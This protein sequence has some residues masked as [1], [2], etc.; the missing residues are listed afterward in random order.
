MIWIRADANSNIGTG[1][2]MRCMSIGHALREC[3]QEVCFLL[4]DASGAK[5]LESRGFSYRILHTNYQDMESELPKLCKWL[6]ENAVS[7]LLIDSYYVTR[8]YLMELRSFTRTAYVD[9]M[10]AFPYPVDLLVNYNIYGDM[11]PYREQAAL[12]DTR[13][14]LGTDYVPLREEFKQVEY[15]VR[16]QGEHVLVTTGGSDLY[17]LAGQLLEKALQKEETRNLHYH[18]VSGA[19]NKNLPALL[20]LEAKYPNVHIY[21]NVTNMA[22]LMRQCDVA[23]SAGGS[24]MYELCAVGVPIIC[25]SFVDNQEQ[26]VQTF[27]KKEVVCYGGNYL[28]QKESLLDDIVKQLA[29]LAGHKEIREQYS[30]RQRRLVDGHGAMRIARELCAQ[31]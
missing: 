31:E 1:H 22:E 29:L 14:L 9:D 10:N 27:V 23:V 24:T 19:F 5:L 7:W 25:F 2:M 26:I 3:G 17:H 21:Q 11:L 13:F 16:E 30:V 12:P 4:A 6:A 28:L 20:T 15:S 8:E 18:V